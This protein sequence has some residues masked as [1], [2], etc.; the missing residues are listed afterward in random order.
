MNVLL[1]LKVVVVLT[2]HVVNVASLVS[3]LGAWLGLINVKR[4]QKEEP[5][6]TAKQHF[7]AVV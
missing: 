5:L 2:P 4:E 1:A 3:E 6:E 7:C